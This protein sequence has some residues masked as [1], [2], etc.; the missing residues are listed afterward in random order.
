VV[1]VGNYDVITADIFNIAE[2]C[3]TAEK[4]KELITAS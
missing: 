4:C 3:A 1:E 2:I